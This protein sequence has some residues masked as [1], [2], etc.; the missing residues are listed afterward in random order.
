MFKSLLQA[1]IVQ[2]GEDKR[3]TISEELQSDFSLNQSLSLYLVDTI[4]RLDVQSETYAL[5]V[6]TLVE[7]ILENPDI[8]LMRQLDKLKQ[9]KMAELKAAGVEFEERVAELDKMENPKPNAEF[10]YETFNA[11]SKAHPWVGQE[12][13]RPKTIA[14]E[15]FE[16]FRSFS[17]YE[18]DYGLERSEGLL[19]RYLSDVYKTILQSVPVLAKTPEIEDIIVYFGAIVRATDS[20]LIDEWER[21]RTGMPLPKIEEQPDTVATSADRTDI[22]RDE[23]GFIVLLRNLLFSVLRSVCREDYVEAAELLDHPDYPMTPDRIGE[24]FNPYYDAHSE[25]RIDATA[26]SPK[27]TRI[28]NKTDLFWDVE[29]IMVDPEEDNDW[30]LVC[31]LDIEKSKLAGH[32]VL[33]VVRVGT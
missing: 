20:S 15:M 11:F 8:I 25:L 13:I 6:L 27:N 9:E 22:T 4:E 24:L 14:R 19:L 12:N 3:V 31:R 30:V 2:V 21:M 18:K 26:R 23:K 1:G 33:Q 10:I 29:Q 16:G 32:V 17:D 7:S 5:D 28:T